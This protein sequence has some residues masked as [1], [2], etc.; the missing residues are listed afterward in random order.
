MINLNYPLT[1]Y[2]YRPVSVPLAALLARTSVTPD[3]V[4]WASTVLAFGAGGALARGHYEAGVAIALAAQIVDCVDGDLARLTGRTSPAGA[5]LD[6]VLDRWADAALILG[7]ALSDFE[8]Y[9][10]IGAVAVTAALVTSYARAR[11]QSL[12]T[13]C[14]E[15]VATRDVRIFIVMVAALTGWVLAGLW[16]LAILGAL[17]SLHRMTIAIR[18]LRAGARGD[19]GNPAP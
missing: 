18:A 7:L 14:P 8:R 13:D 9:G 15:G 10:V 12:G 17:T 19:I 3:Q 5:Y 4:T 1:R 16:V 6:S 11:A 2:L